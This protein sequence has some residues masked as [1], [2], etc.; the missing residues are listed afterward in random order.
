[1]SADEV[2]DAIRDLQN[3]DARQIILDLRSNPG[4]LV[5]ESV[6][7]ASMF[8]PEGSL[9][10]R[11]RGK[12]KEMDEDFVTDDDGR[13]RDLPLILL[14]NSHSASASEALAGSLQDHDRALIIGRRSFGKAL[15]QTGFPVMPTGDYVVLTVGRIYTPSGRIIQ[16]RYRGLGDAQYRSLAGTAGDAQDTLQEFRTDGGRVVRGGGG[17]APD[18]ELPGGTRFPVWVAVAADSGFEAA[19]ADS[20]AATLPADA[21]AR[22]TWLA[23]PERWQSALIAPYLDRVRTRLGI[24]AATTPELEERIAWILARRAARV[25]WGNEAA[26]ET[27]LRYDA[28]V[29]AAIENF[30]NIRALLAGSP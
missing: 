25:R 19:V 26:S 10:F 6:E 30:P 3:Q 28:D 21:T 2:E 23:S 5:D 29:Q 1:E 12:K 9:V 7:M 22:E 17:I 4:G 8:L 15:I 18:I 11:S 13:F 27:G 14:I 20:V 24:S 16:R